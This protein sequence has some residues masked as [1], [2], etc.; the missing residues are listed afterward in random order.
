MAVSQTTT[1]CDFSVREPHLAAMIAGD[2]E[3]APTRLSSRV[4]TRKSRSAIGLRWFWLVLYCAAIS[5]TGCSTLIT[6]AG[7]SRPLPW[8]SSD[9]LSIPYLVRLA[10]FE[11]GNLVPN[12]SFEKGVVVTRDAGDTFSLPGWEIIGEHVRWMHPHSPGYE[13]QGVNEGQ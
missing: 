13:P 12:P 3:G 6:T 8:S 7:P 11:K 5:L 4:E 1:V 10:Q 2:R 9:P